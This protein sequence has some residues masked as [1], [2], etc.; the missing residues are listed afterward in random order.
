MSPAGPASEPTIWLSGE[1]VTL[2]N[3]LL[4]PPLWIGVLGGLL[5]WVFLTTGR[6]RVAPGFRWLAALVVA[7]TIWM[8]WFTARLQRVGYSGRELVVANYWREAR[9]PFDNVAAVE[10][11]W[12]YPRRMVCVRFRSRTPFGWTVYYLPKW[13][14]FRLLMTAPDEEL[15]RIIS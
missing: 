7:M 12:W 6:I 2:F 11:V 8:L 3:K 5:G 4:F 15:R 1:F 13:G 9:M 10:P 14:P